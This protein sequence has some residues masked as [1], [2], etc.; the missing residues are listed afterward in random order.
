MAPTAKWPRVAAV[1]GGLGLGARRHFIEAHCM[2]CARH[3]AFVLAF[4]SQQTA[5]GAA[6]SSSICSRALQWSMR[7]RQCGEQEEGGRSTS[8]PGRCLYTA[9]PRAVLAPAL[10]ISILQALASTT[11]AGLDRW[12]TLRPVIYNRRSAL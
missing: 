4:I 8:L 5:F 10:S 12:S 2:C 7:R 3:L 1:E 11:K 6:D 9:K